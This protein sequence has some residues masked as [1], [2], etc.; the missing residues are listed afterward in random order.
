[1]RLQ[2]RHDSD[3]RSDFFPLVYHVPISI[4]LARAR[5]DYGLEQV[6]VLG[7]DRWGEDGI[8]REFWRRLE[9]FDGTLVSF[10]GRGFDLP[11][12]ELNGLRYRCA[13]PRYYMT[14]G[15]WRQRFGRHVDLQEWFSNYGA[16]RLRGGL[17]VL[18]K[19]AG[20]PGKGEIS[21]ADVQRL[22]ERHCWADIHRYCAADAVQTYLIFLRVEQLC[23]RLDSER[24]AA[25][26]QAADALLAARSW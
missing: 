5:A 18:A 22:W 11:V 7:A 21:G 9:E 19:L 20:L 23:G 6:D 17:D 14:R 25:L 15:G 4:A 2:L 12:L 13:A 24:I 26:E 16:V 1:M 8:V 10:N 3:G